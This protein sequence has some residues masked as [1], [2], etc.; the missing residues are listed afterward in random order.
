MPRIRSCRPVRRQGY[1]PVRVPGASINAFECRGPEQGRSPDGRT[2]AD[3]MGATN[4][5]PPGSLPALLQSVLSRRAGKLPAGC[6]TSASP[7]LPTA[8]VSGLRL[9]SGS[10]REYKRSR[11][12]G[13]R[14]GTEPG[15]VAPKRTGWVPRTRIRQVFNAGRLASRQASLFSAAIA[16]AFCQNASPFARTLKSKWVACR[17]SS[18]STPSGPGW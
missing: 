1:G 12:P 10:R 11:A 2:K 13:T 16:A 14:T 7:R 17:N 15:L 3:R 4:P 6:S 18:N 5:H 9:C 8:T